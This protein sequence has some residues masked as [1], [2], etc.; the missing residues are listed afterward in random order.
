VHLAEHNFTQAVL[1]LCSVSAS[2]GNALPCVHAEDLGLAAALASAASESRVNMKLRLDTHF[3][4]NALEVYPLAEQVLSGMA[5]ARYGAAADAL[6]RLVPTLSCDPFLQP[7]I[8]SLTNALR[9][10]AITLYVAPFSSV[11]LTVAA[12]ALLPASAVSSV[13]VGT[14]A[15]AL[16][17]EIASL[18]ESNVVAGHIDAVAL[19]FRSRDSRLRDNAYESILS[20]AANYESEAQAILLSSSLEA[21]R[22][23]LKAPRE[24]GERGSSAPNRASHRGKSDLGGEALS[25]P[26]PPDDDVDAH[27]IDSAGEIETDILGA[28]SLLGGN[29]TDFGTYTDA[30]FGA[31]GLPAAQSNYGQ[32]H[33]ISSFGRAHPEGGGAEYE[34]EGGLAGR[35]PEIRTDIP[36]DLVELVGVDFLENMLQL[37]RV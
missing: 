14:S 12:K 13:D 33:L 34:A 7:L 4:R 3:I 6:Q 36:K 28:L 25:F 5:N 11:D 9:K 2:M 8:S 31:G 24:G 27:S 18:I 29:E 35:F 23:R 21:A 15:R 10:R 20:V 19:T 37:T 32:P 16:A 17:V 26:A 1:A 22:L 30:A